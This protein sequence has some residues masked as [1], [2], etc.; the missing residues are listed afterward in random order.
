MTEPH[1]A[2]RELVQ[3]AHDE[4]PDRIE[5]DTE[6]GLSEIR[7]RAPD[8]LQQPV[9]D[10]NEVR[11]AG[12]QLSALQLSRDIVTLEARPESETLVRP[13]TRTAGPVR[14]HDIPVEALVTIAEHVDLSTV[15]V[16][17]FR[18]ICEICTRPTAMMEIAATL[19]MPY[20]IVRVII[21]DM[22]DSRL[23]AVTPL[24][25]G[26]DGRPT[27]ELMTNVL[28]HLRDL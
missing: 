23:A 13:Y 25:L 19:G 7:S 14:P 12:F 20:G 15:R 21:G 9:V 4:D 27:L 17:E 10:T 8:L 26:K 5:F 24:R 28:D 16:P 2:I 6:A 1:D 18:R 3:R 22:I 11:W